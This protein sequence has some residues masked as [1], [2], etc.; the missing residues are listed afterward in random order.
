MSL[1]WLGTQSEGLAQDQAYPPFGSLS[2]PCRPGQREEL[3]CLV[4]LLSPC[5]HLAAPVI[6][7]L[8]S[9]IWVHVICLLS[10]SLGI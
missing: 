4:P 3:T 2:A 9:L 8:A 6:G 7:K 10:H 1:L 5:A